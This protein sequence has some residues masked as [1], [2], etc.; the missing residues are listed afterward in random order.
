MLKIK[1]NPQ[2]PS[3]KIKPKI[4]PKNNLSTKITKQQLT[5]TQYSNISQLIKSNKISKYFETNPTQ[6]FTLKK[7]NSISN[8]NLYRKPFRKKKNS[9]SSSTSLPP[10]PNNSP[11]QLRKS[12]SISTLQILK[13]TSKKIKNEKTFQLSN[14]NTTTLTT[15]IKNKKK[16]TNPTFQNTND[17]NTLI[18]RSN[19]KI[20][21]AN[22]QKRNIL[23]KTTK[24]IKTNIKHSNKNTNS[25]N[26]KSLF[27]KIQK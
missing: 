10:T 17:N 12:S 23:K 22:N 24:F 14:H 1:T 26:N 15:H 21:S 13:K 11:K 16:K 8:L 18:K 9:S 20:I 4:K 27:Q 3:S 6:N 7:S 2:L 19:R 5:N 25:H